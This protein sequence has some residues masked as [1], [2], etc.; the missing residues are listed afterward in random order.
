M[1]LFGTVDEILEKDF[2]QIYEDSGI[3]MI[4]FSGYIYTNGESGY[5]ENGK[6]N[7]EYC[8]R[9]VEESGM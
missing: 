4:S 9:I 6:E 2:F 1:G 7:N 5:D 3:K 8:Y